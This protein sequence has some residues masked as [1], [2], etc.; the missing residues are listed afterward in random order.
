MECFSF[1]IRLLG[2]ERM[3]LTDLSRSKRNPSVPEK[4]QGVWFVADMKGNAVV[5]IDLNLM[6][7]VDNKGKCFAIDTWCDYQS[8][9]D[10]WEGL[11]LWIFA[12]LLQIRSDLDTT[13]G[14]VRWS[15]FRGLL[16]LPF[17]SPTQHTSD[18]HTVKR[19][20]V[21]RFSGKILSE[22]HLWRVVDQH[23]ERTE[24][25]SKMLDRV[26]ATVLIR[27]RCRVKVA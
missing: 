11:W 27:P 25:F 19:W 2:L 5:T 23:G 17:D 10:S 24:H 14:M 15:A 12:W 20:I 6:Q 13:D 18:P 22:Y 4:I 8:V 16:P 3:N 9:L 26:G 1:L 21:E 7:P